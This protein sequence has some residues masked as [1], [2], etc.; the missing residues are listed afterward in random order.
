MDIQ[1]LNPVEVEENLR[2]L[3]N[4]IARSVKIVSRTYAEFLEADRAYDRAYAAA[5]LK[6][7]GSVEEKK[8][9]ARYATLVEREARDV[10]DVAYRY[11]N[12]RATA[13]REELR[14]TQSVGASVRAMYGIAGRGEW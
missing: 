4:E 6:A 13:L 5:Y 3:S 12:D 8:Q 11:A 14:A 9:K 7:S 10:A 2:R 1:P